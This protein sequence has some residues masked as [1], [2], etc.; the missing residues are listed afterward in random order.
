MP[1]PALAPLETTFSLE[2]TAGGRAR[3]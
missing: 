1:G 3:A 2:G